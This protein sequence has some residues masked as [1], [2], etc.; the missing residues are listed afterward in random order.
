MVA[1]FD[2]EKSMNT[3]ILMIYMNNFNGET[4]EDHIISS[5]LKYNLTSNVTEITHTFKDQSLV[6]LDSVFKKMPTMNCTLDL[7]LQ[8]LNLSD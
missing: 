2:I 1:G 3:T 7:N 5:K 4:Y 8:F 6:K